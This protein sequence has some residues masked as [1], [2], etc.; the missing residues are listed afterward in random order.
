[1]LPLRHADSSSAFCDDGLITD[2][3]PRYSTTRMGVIKYLGRT[4][5]LPLDSGDYLPQNIQTAQ[6]GIRTR[7]KEG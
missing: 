3:P 7:A 1:M 4:V 6:T 5:D 2:E